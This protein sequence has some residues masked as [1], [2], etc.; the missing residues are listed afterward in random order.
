MQ[1]SCLI[2]KSLSGGTREE[3]AK[4]PEDEAGVVLDVT[5]G[6]TPRLG[7][8]AEDPFK[9]GAHHP[10]RRLWLAA[11]EEVECGA[12]AKHH[13]GTAADV[14]LLWAT[15]ADEEQARAGG[16]D[17]L[18]G[19]GVLF[20]RESSKRRTLKK[21]NMEIWVPPTHGGDEQIETCVAAAIKAY[22]DAGSLGRG[23]QGDRGIG[24][25]DALRAALPEP[26]KR[27]NKRHSVGVDHV[28]VIEP[29]KES[30]IVAGFHDDVDIGEEDCARSPLAGPEETSLN[31]LVVA[32]DGNIDPENGAGYDHTVH[33]L[34][35]ILKKSSVEALQPQ[36]PIAPQQ[37]S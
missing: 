12:D 17:S 9:P 28:G 14:L 29:A 27:P 15:E 32:A 10:S 6:Q 1:L 13:C 35:S 34:P 2:K 16:S 8:E 30:G 20:W 5:H 4:E 25:V 18:D 37:A 24:A 33:N 21:I 36:D 7:D 22:R 23:K 19:S 11:G 31:H 3:L 26:V